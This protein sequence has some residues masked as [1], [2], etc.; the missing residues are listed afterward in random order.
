MSTIVS[1]E[2]QEQIRAYYK[3]RPMTVSEVTKKFG[4]CTQTVIKILGDIPRYTKTQLWSPDLRED[5]FEC[6]DTEEKAYFLGLMITDGNVFKANDHR[7][8]ISFTLDDADAYLLEY[9]RQC[10][11]ATTVISH[12]GR[13]CSQHALR[14]L[15]MANDL[16]KYGVVPRK[17]LHAYLP[18]IEDESQMRHLIRGLIDGDGGIYAYLPDN[19]TKYRHKI[20]LCGTRALME[21]VVEY[22]TPVLQ[23][24]FKP[25]V[26]SYSNR[27][28]SEF[29]VS[30]VQDMNKLGDW[31][32]KGATVYMDRKYQRF[33]EF[34][35]HY[36]IAN[37]EVSRQITKG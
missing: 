10:V 1:Q 27:P 13:G 16:A 35:R 32:Y 12:D 31:L 37:T 14:S 24:S 22:I 26:Y 7:A 3:S 36:G 2:E 4:Y 23:L 6:I 5:F 17:T 20:T 8:S 18:T 28:L 11:N 33:L 9:W 34:Q 21:G 29:R 30:N 19:S 25:K 15:K